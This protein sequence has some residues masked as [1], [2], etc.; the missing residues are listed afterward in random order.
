MITLSS[1]NY[2]KNVQL[3]KV[4]NFEIAVT[5]FIYV[6]MLNLQAWLKHVAITYLYLQ[7]VI[8]RIPVCRYGYLFL[9]YVY[10]CMFV[11]L[12]ACVYLYV[13]VCINTCMQVLG[14]MRV[15]ISV[16][17]FGDCGFGAV[18]L[19]TLHLIEQ[20]FVFHKNSPTIIADL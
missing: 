10:L 15:Q 9:A 7:S 2:I 5:N 13:C 19:C 16:L 17:V 12:I 4:Q 8:Y 14:S 1:S 3:F 11:Y 6:Q 20:V 18:L